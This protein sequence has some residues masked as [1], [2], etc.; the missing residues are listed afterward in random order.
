M[1]IW[2]YLNGNQQGPYTLDELRQ[3]NLTSSTPVW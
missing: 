1:K 3:L 2:V